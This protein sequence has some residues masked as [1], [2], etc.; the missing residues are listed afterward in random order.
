MAQEAPLAINIKAIFTGKQAFKQAD[1]ATTKLAKGAE[2]LAGVLGLAYST[3]AIVQYVKAASMAAAADQQAQAVLANNLKNLGLSYASV[4]SEKFIASLE[5]QTSILDDELRP[6][7][8]QL[9]RVTGSIVKTQE[10]MTVAFDASKG[11]GLSYAS[12]V[13]IISQAYVGNNKGLKQLNLGLTTAEL[14]AMSF[15]QILAVITDRFNGAGKQALKGY[16]GQMAA[17]DLA[18]KNSSETLG[19]AFLDAFSKLAGNGDITKATSKIDTFSTTVAGLIRL[20]TGVNSLSAAM[21]SIDWQSTSLIPGLK[22]IPTA[23]KTKPLVAGQSP[24]DRLAIDKANKAALAK[25]KADAAQ[26]AAT[27]KLTAL[28]AA[29]AKKADLAAKNQIALTK[30]AAAFDLK[31]ISIANAL[32]ETYDKD[33]KLRLL[34]MQAIENDNG[35]AALDYLKQLGILQKAV[36][37]DKLNG[38]TTISDASLHALNVEL[39]TE[40]QNIDASKMKDA[41]KEAAKLAAFAKYNDAIIKEGGLAETSYYNE[42]TQI[43]LTYIAKRA[44]LDNYGAASET[45]RKIIESEELSLIKTVSTAQYAADLARYNS[46]ID[47]IRLL[48]EAKAAAATLATDIYTANLFGD[49]PS[50]GAAD[51]NLGGDSGDTGGGAGGDYGDPSYPDTGG[52]YG[53]PSYPDLGGG[54]GGDYGSPS[55]PDAMSNTNGITVIVNTGATLG[56]EEVIVQAVQDAMQTLNRRGSNV[57]YAGAI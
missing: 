9:A 31:Q 23:K 3:K 38:I 32:K 42:R 54:A 48:G 55:Y 24:G 15:D 7:Y 37:T 50:S 22:I 41:D 29:A 43:E 26:L 10:L 21:D 13:D 56:S 2:K 8:A 30:A 19:G 6:A 35:E 40:L 12:T 5:K 45:L 57:S 51:P 49:L 18:V 25:Q 14:S 11:A 4:D 44:A 52:D 28:Q 17:F 33:T 47:Y 53:D 34:A 20:L 39:L 27:K 36:Q 1:T 46:L 16:A